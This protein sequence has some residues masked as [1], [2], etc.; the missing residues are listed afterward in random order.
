MHLAAVYNPGQSLE[1]Y[2]NG[3]LDNTLTS[4]V[5]SS[6]YNGNINAVIG[7]R[8]SM[9]VSDDWPGFFHGIIDE[10]KVFGSA[11]SASDVAL[12]AA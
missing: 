2:I 6:Q 3:V 12:L 4:G 8:S 9:G 5:P 11:L 10:L 1:I 7:R